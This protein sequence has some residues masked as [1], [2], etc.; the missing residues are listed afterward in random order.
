MLRAAADRIADAGGRVDDD[1]PPVE[2]AQQRELFVRMIVPA[3]APSLPDEQ[4]DAVVGF[5][6]RVAPRRGGP[7][8]AAPHVGRVVRR[9]R[10]AP[11]P[12]GDGAGVPPRPRARH[13]ASA[14]SRS[15]GESRAL[16]ST[17]DWLGLI[18][19]VG[20]PSAVVPIGRTAAGLPVGMQIV[21]PYL[22]D[23]RAVRAAQLVAAVLGG[24][25]APPGF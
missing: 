22:H 15:T 20:L 17:I 24:Y 19:I 10:P 16:V 9:P 4:A 14:P 13:V 8:R 18:G 2:F 1:R 6:P 23:R 5:A 12:G 21:A 7:R 25:T 11:A 3:M